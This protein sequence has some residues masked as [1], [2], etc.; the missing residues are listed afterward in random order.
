[1][2]PYDGNNRVREAD[3]LQDFSADHGVNLHLL[4]LF[5]TQSSGFGDDVFWYGELSDVVGYLRALVSD[6]AFE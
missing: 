6:A 2:G 5:G 4:K 3:A 1:M